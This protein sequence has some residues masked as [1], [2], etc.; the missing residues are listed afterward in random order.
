MNRIFRTIWNTSLGVWVAVSEIANAS[1]N[2]VSSR[3]TLSL[4]KK[5]FINAFPVL[6]R[7]FKLHTLAVLFGAS[8]I[9]PAYGQITTQQRANANNIVLDQDV[10]IS[11]AASGTPGYGLWAQNGGQISASTNQI[12][13]ASALSSALYAESG[14]QIV[15]NGTDGV[16]DLSNQNSGSSVPIIV[17]TGNGT[18]VDLTGATIHGNTSSVNNFTQSVVAL[19]GASLNLTDS[20][21]SVVGGTQDSQSGPVGIYISGVGTTANLD[22]VELNLSTVSTRGGGMSGLMVNGQATVVGSDLTI[23]VSSGTAGPQVAIASSGSGTNVTLNNT[24]LMGTATATANQIITAMQAISG[25]ALTLNGGSISGNG[26]TSGLSS[27]GNNSVLNANNFNVSTAKS[28]G[29][30]LVSAANGGVLNFTGGTISSTPT[31]GMTLVYAAVLNSRVNLKDA[32]VV[33]QKGGATSNI[34]GVGLYIHGAAS[35]IADN[36]LIDIN[37]SSGNLRVI[38]ATA[39]QGNTGSQIQLL[40]G[41][42]I[43]VVGGYSANYGGSYGVLLSGTGNNFTGSDSSVTVSRSSPTV[44]QGV[45]GIQIQNGATASLTNMTI[46]AT[47]DGSQAVVGSGSGTQINLNAGNTITTNGANGH[48]LAVL[49]GATLNGLTASGTTITTQGSGAN[50]LYLAGPATANSVNLNNVSLSSAQASA[51]N[52]AS[53][54]ANIELSGGSVTA[55]TRPWLNVAAGASAQVTLKD[56]Q[57]VTGSTQMLA[58]GTSDLLL[59]SGATWELTANSQLSSLAFN[60]GKLIF[61]A[62]AA[63]TTNSPVTLSGNGGEFDSNGLNVSFANQLQGNGQ[64][65]KSGAGTLTLTSTGSSI[66]GVDVQSGVL[67]FG[68]SGTFSTSGDFITRNGATTQL[69]FIPTQINV[70]GTFTQES[71]STLDVTVG[72]RPDI[73]ADH[74]ILDGEL[75]ISGFQRDTYPVKAS[76]VEANPYTIIHTTGPL[77]ISGNFTNQVGSDLGIDYLLEQGYISADNQDYNI[78]FRMAWTDGGQSQGSG[79]FTL[80]DVN[81]AFNVDLALHD[82][83]VPSGGFDSGWSGTTLTKKG[84]GLLVLSALNTYSGKTDVMGGSL[85]LAG[86]GDIGA[87][88]QLLL[89]GSDSRFD[90]SYLTGSSTTINNLAGVS[91]SRVTLSGGNPANLSA[92]TLVIHN[93]ANADSNGNTEFSGVIDDA[94]LGSN[95][96]KTGAGSLTLSG[97]NTYTGMTAVDEGSLFIGSGGTSGSLMSAQLTIAD[98]ST[99]IFN[100]A[101]SSEYAGL[102]TGSAGSTLI[103]R[104]NGIL[105]LSMADSLFGSSTVE[106]GTLR[107]NQ[108]GVITSIGD[109]T[110]MGGA[111]LDLG[112]PGSYLTVDSN[113]NM[114]DGSTLN[115]F[116]DP[117]VGVQYTDIYAQQAQ[118]G[119]DTT[120][121]I[122]GFSA[123]YGLPNSSDYHLTDITVLHT[124]NGLNFTHG[125]TDFATLGVDGA[126]SSVDYLVVE[127]KQIGGTDYNIG[128]G[129]SWYG[130]HFNLPAGYLPTGNFTLTN[131]NEVF[132]VDAALNNESSYGQS[133]DAD[134]WDG[135]SL[136]KKGQGTLLLSEANTYTGDTV[137]E[138]GGLSLLGNGD[139]SYSRQLSL[140]GADANFN[141]SQVNSAARTIHNLTGVAGSQIILGDK[142]LTVNNA[143]DTLFSGD[144]ITAEGSLSKTGNGELILAGYT[145]WTG[146]TELQAGTLTLDGSNGGAQLVSDI[147]G[148]NG[149]TLN[150]IHGA[151]LTGAIDPADVNIDRD[152][153]W[154][155]TASSQVNHLTLAGTVNYSQPE[156]PLNAGR[157]LNVANWAGDGGSISLYSALGGD[158]AITDKLV[159]DGDTS[160]S[161]LVKVTNAGGSGAQTLKGIELIEVKGASNGEFVQ[162]G[163]IVA[164]A[165]DYSLVRGTE[166]RANNW[167]L[168]SLAPKP[169]P[170]PDP[171]PE[172]KRPEAGSYIA[173]LAAANTLFI[174]SLHDRLGET[175]YIDALSGE[176][177]VT[178][179]WLRSIGGHNRWRDNSDQIKTQSDRY[180]IQMGGDIAQW[181]TDGLDRWHL[182]LM[183]GYGN[184][185]SN[186]GSRLSGYSSDG[187]VD[188]YSLGIYGTWYANQQDKSGLYLDSWAQYGWFDNQVNGQDIG[189]ENYHSSGITASVESGYTFKMGETINSDSNRESYFIQPKLQVIWMGVSADDHHEANGTRVSGKGDGN[190]MTRLGLRAYMQGHSVIDDGKD[191]QFQPFIEANWIHNSDDFGT[192]MNGVTVTQA[193]A[194]NRG[195]LKL[196]VEGQ[197]SPRLNLWGNVG[198]QLGDKGYSDTAIVLG[199]KYNF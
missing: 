21:I 124:L 10:N 69:G 177:K 189:Q 151:S 78:G 48:G 159:I 128:V 14:G 112:N 51:I 25:G 38:G 60:D 66:G 61:S 9:F 144:F 57:R 101:D 46:Q 178:S 146:N 64:L 196:G 75:V 149:S 116:I 77:G 172:I 115:V 85:S 170:G 107:L 187:S 87:S 148:S 80:N 84:A 31:Q 63:I 126:G 181:S 171:S 90:I 52:I 4:S 133:G 36:T 7:Q 34:N 26:I 105:T 92:K 74:A 3:H 108:V 114:Q 199:V 49:N 155:M 142:T 130:T 118:I 183:A 176:K 6:P 97:D 180:V 53:G 135:Q 82:Q 154:N 42:K 152:S 67:N 18:S 127:G 153:L 166:D 106:A 163:R 41:S 50:A 47:G 8:F 122:A 58:T 131:A 111:A 91:G 120:L 13:V 17:A 2:N 139:I 27:N 65:L 99:V 56:S 184:S 11:L 79:D 140:N 37:A 20:T 145:G 191:R 89:S 88:S 110:L 136:T 125:A 44:G 72:A 188:G 147:I 24:T 43:N 94:G 93:V 95:L 198:Q 12:S 86:N 76:E 138:Q 59:N 32:T 119:S 16:L 62:N 175:Q 132:Q 158:D 164:G 19:A 22:Q 29:S 73:V 33:M 28:N 55:G 134:Y 168:T 40:N 167:Y 193:G 96:T 156:G 39:A 102:I 113:F 98:N 121:N 157:T 141:I 182:G 174:T 186:S 15:L 192:T 104:G 137:I 150:L 169:E 143:T 100:R 123:T 23:N 165:Y 109:F 160:G 197:W 190:V 162:N 173:N 117:K 5:S 179:M 103:K 161:T 195:E 35:I 71:G 70:G 83:S 185:Q 54:S 129:L 194:K 68:Q 45:T 1:K 30:Q 81:D